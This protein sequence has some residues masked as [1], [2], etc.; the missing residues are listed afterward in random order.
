[1]SIIRIVWGL[2]T[3][4]NVFWK[5]K[6]GLCEKPLATSLALKRSTNPSGFLLILNSQ[7]QFMGC[8]PRGSGTN[9]HVWLLMRPLSSSFKAV[10]LQECCIASWMFDGSVMVDR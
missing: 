5:S 7:F 9:V 1:M 2:T 6:H 10:S 8:R 3:G 4:L